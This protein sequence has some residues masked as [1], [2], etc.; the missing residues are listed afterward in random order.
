M[1]SFGS[2]KRSGL[3][4]SSPT[5]VPAYPRD[6]RRSWTWVS[7]PAVERGAV[8]DRPTSFSP[9]SQRR[10][11]CW[12]LIHDVLL[13]ERI[14]RHVVQLRPWRVNQFEPL[15]PERSQRR[16]TQAPGSER[17]KA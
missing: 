9:R 3:D 14:A 7:I 6:E 16:P 12:M 15:I 4:A 11:D 17:L 8:A 1:Q 13:F 2:G 10:S 5:L